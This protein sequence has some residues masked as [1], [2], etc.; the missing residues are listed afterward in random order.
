MRHTLGS[1]RGA[2]GIDE[3]RRL[4]RVYRRE[5]PLMRLPSFEHRQLGKNGTPAP[6]LLDQRCKR[7]FAEAHSGLCMIQDEFD[8]RGFESRIDRD[9]G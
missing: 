6:N 3:N 1:R 7:R 4:I 5:R 8:L 9:G 2:G